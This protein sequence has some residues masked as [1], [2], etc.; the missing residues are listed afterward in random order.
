M[1]FE[2]LQLVVVEKD[3]KTLSD[4]HNVSD[5]AT[6][7]PNCDQDYRV[8]FEEKV[9]KLVDGIVRLRFG[10]H[11]LQASVLTQRLREGTRVHDGDQ[12]S[13][14]RM[15]FERILREDLPHRRAQAEEMVRTAL[16]Q[17]AD[18]NKAELLSTRRENPESCFYVRFEAQGGNR[19]SVGQGPIGVGQ[20]TIQVLGQHASSVPPP[21]GSVVINPAA[22]PR[23]HSLSGPYTGSA[24]Y[25]ILNN[26]AAHHGNMGHQHLS[27]E[28]AQPHGS[29]MLLF[30]A[31]VAANGENCQQLLEPNVAETN[32]SN[33]AF[34]ID[35]FIVWFPKSD[36]ATYGLTQHILRHAITEAMAAPE[37]S[38][39]CDGVITKMIHEPLPVRVR[40]FM[41][42]LHEKRVTG[43]F[44]MGSMPGVRPVG[45]IHLDETLTTG[46]F[47][48]FELDPE[49]KIN[50][51][52]R[53]LYKEA[54]NRSIVWL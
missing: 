24:F 26:R 44:L 1:S 47:T 33:I 10:V 30:T 18:A 20:S 38:L 11:L 12:A 13:S 16:R 21:P 31:E 14:L 22:P 8:G 34:V 45:E 32:F 39:L 35:H 46:A 40:Q 15:R 27:A 36:S 53:Q 29:D 28:M 23:L 4:T 17:F 42:Q 41:T 6:N 25:P 7:D 51:V 48:A 5:N 19:E 50:L 9:K 54:Y 49:T 37:D 2:G 43:A 3:E 52:L